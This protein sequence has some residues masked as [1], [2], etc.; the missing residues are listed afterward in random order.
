M[1]ECAENISEADL[2]ED[3]DLWKESLGYLKQPE[4]YLT[5]PPTK[6]AD[7]GTNIS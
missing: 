7:N 1:T 6:I 3:V 2:R 4:A 5:E